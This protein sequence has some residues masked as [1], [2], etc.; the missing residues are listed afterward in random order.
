MPL[1]AGRHALPQVQLT[2]LRDKRELAACK[3]KR[4]VWI[5]PGAALARLRV[6][7]N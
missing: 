5:A 2:A 1:R 3:A 6:T 4:Y 7:P